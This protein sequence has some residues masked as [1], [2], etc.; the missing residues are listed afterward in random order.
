MLDFQGPGI[1]IEIKVM[2]VGM[3]KCKAEI[4]LQRIEDLGI[5]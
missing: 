5:V 1:E 3:H 2:E 4:H